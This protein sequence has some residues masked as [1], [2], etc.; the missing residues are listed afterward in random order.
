M[1]K[2]VW[3]TSDT[4]FGHSNIIKYCNRPFTSIEEMTEG[5]IDNFNQ[6]VKPGDTLY[7][8]GDISLNKEVDTN[9]ILS[10]INGTKHLLTGNHD[11]VYMD[12]LNLS[13]ESIQDYAVV[14]VEGVTLVLMHFP[15]LSWDRRQHGAIH[16]HGHTHG[17]L[18]N[19]GTLRFDVGV[20]CWGMRPVCLDQILELLP[21]RFD[22]SEGLL[23]GSI[24]SLNKAREKYKR[25]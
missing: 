1:T 15:I 24:N 8:L 21:E 19:S 10:R 4:H 9:K 18:N 6:I 12:R 11:R 20:D 17:G 13:F 7:H 2:Q 16:L 22:Q 23:L 5:L 25:V 3:F 14:K